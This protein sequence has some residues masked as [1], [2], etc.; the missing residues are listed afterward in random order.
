MS[1]EKATPK[2]KPQEKQK[3]PEKVDVSFYLLKARKWRT[4]ICVGKTKVEIKGENSIITIS[5]A[6][7]LYDGKVDFLRKYKGN[8]K[9]GGTEFIELT[10]DDVR[11]G[12]QCL[13]DSLL[14]MTKESLLG[15]LSD[16]D[17]KNRALSRGAIMML[18]MKEKDAI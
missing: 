17:P 16:K 6:D 12:G 9:N 1:E 5:K 4:L 3:E 2:A 14:E 13:L 15:V 7:P 10:A 8:R 18:I 11:P